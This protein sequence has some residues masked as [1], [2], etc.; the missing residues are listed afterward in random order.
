MVPGTMLLSGAPRTGDFPYR[1]VGCG[2]YA[3]SMT[4][5]LDLCAWPA[6]LSCFEDDLTDAHP[7][8]LRIAIDT[9]TEILWALTGRKY[10]VCPAETQ[11]RPDMC[12]P[13]M[14]TLFR[15]DWYNVDP[16][17]AGCQA[18]WLPQPVFEV[19]DVLD[20]DG[21]TLPWHE[22]AYGV[23]VLGPVATVKYMRGLQVPD[24]AGYM[25]GRLASQRYLQC[26]GDRKRCQL[27]S[28]TTSVTRQGVSVQMA[29]PAEVI[30]M[31]GTGLPDVDAW[32]KAH[33]PYGMAQVSEVIG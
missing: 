19:L 25:V 5:P 33:N 4:E 10:G 23:D 24:T 17:Q 13:C 31:G 26:I 29:D 7:D 3:G 11:V 21:A 30:S 18:V 32:V 20:A 9:A 2:G 14:P 15:G 22:T 16:L 8:K 1:G 6:D 27:P 12:R 28:N